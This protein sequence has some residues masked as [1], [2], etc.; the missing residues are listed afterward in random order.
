MLFTSFTP[1]KIA[2]KIKKKNHGYNFRIQNVQF[3]FNNSLPCVYTRDTDFRQTD[4]D[5]EAL[6]ILYDSYTPQ[7]YIP[8]H[9]RTNHS[10]L[11]ALTVPSRHVT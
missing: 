10:K 1:Q 9:L 4:P 6:S 3:K 7:F 2:Y 11:T 8:L 5:R